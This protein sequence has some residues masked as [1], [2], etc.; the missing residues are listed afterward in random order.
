VSVNV[1]KPHVLVLPEDDANRQIVNGFLLDP[2][3]NLR[4]IQALPIAKVCGGMP[5]WRT[6]RQRSGA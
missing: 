2:S 4:A 5:C 3:L 6:T 1:F